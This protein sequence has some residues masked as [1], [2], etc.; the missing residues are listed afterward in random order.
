MT[1]TWARLLAVAAAALIPFALSLVILALTPLS[2]HESITP[3][4]EVARGTVT[5]LWALAAVVVYLRQPSSTLW[6]LL[7]VS[8]WVDQIWVLP[9]ITTD[10]TFTLG[11]A[12]RDLAVVLFA[13]IVV[14]FPT[15]T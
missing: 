11:W 7:L 12:L 14:S 6:K 10:L 5:T 1:A 4:S 9:S 8:A 13:H 3:I 15:G 2:V